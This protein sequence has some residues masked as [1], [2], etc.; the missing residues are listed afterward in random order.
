MAIP[1]FLSA[2]GFVIKA[3]ENGLLWWVGNRTAVP[4]ASGTGEVKSN[5]GMRGH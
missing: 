2:R 4:H 5:E 3:E 1:K